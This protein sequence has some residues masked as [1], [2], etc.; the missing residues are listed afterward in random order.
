MRVR[1]FPGATQ[2]DM[3]DYIRPLAQKQPLHMII[4]CGTNDLTSTESENEIVER[5]Q[6]LVQLIKSLSPRTH[7][8]F[9]NLITRIDNNNKYTNKVDLIN[10]AIEEFF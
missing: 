7:I 8:V 3:E 10:K 9:S 1:C 4:H 5:L 2:V 6:H